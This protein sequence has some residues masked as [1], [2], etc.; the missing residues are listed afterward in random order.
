MKISNTEYASF[1][2]TYISR[3]PDHENLSS[4]L[5]TTF[6]TIKLFL[7][8][9][10][11]EKMHFAYAEGKWTI[12]Q[13]I[14]HCIDVERLMAARALRA[15]RNDKTALPGFDEN[16]YSEAAGK[17]DRTKNNL[18]EEWELLRKS[19]ILMFDSF[20]KDSLIQK[21]TI[22]KHETSTRALG[23][24]I[25]GHSLHHLNVLKDRYTT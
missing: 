2:E 19:N 4:H 1:Y 25:I 18:I 17:I 22:W 10:P 15:A 23:L 7:S 21:T 13:L 11:D 20:S 24:I 14:Q 8:R 6:E 3:I 12:A 9:I 5:L 16:N